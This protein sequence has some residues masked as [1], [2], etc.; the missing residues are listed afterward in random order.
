MRGKNKQSQLIDD[1]TR[2]RIDILVGT[3]M[4]VKGLD[5]EQVGLVGILSADSLLNYPDFRVNERGFQLMEQ[6]SGRAGRLDGK[7]LVIIQT[8][9]LRHPVLQ[10]VKEH[11]FRGFYQAEVGMRQQFGY[12]PFTRMVRLTCRHRDMQKAAQGAQALAEALQQIPD[13]FIQGPAAALVPRVRNFYLQELWL[14]LPKEAALLQ[15]GKEGISAAI[16]AVMQQRGNAALQI[17]ADVDP[18]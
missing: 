17:I 3:Q 5:F 4:V 9:N 13:I 1:F 8:F 14:K 15:Q 18:F 7:G 12:P 11:D 2:G 6:V 16:N 10:W